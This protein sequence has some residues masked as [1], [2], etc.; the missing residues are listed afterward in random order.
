MPELK[1]QLHPLN[2]MAQALWLYRKFE[3]PGPT[4]VIR[5]G[6]DH[7]DSYWI[8]VRTTDTARLLEYL[9]SL[10]GVAEAYSISSEP[11]EPAVATSTDVGYGVT[12]ENSEPNAPFAL[13]TLAN[14]ISVSLSP[15]VE[16]AKGSQPK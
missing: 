11:V 3:G 9:R 15:F 12:E 13:R 4:G 5:F 2:N 6:R 1:L 10:D 14:S 16:L 8:L 7:P